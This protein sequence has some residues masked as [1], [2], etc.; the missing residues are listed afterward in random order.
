VTLLEPRRR[1]RLA[2][3]GSRLAP[4]RVRP[5][6]VVTVELYFRC[7]APTAGAWEVF[8]HADA[9]PPSRKPRVGNGDHGFTG[10]AVATSG[11]RRGQLLLDRWDLEISSGA[12]TGTYQLFAGLWYP[13]EGDRMTVRP[14]QAVSSP[15]SDGEPLGDEY[16]DRVYLGDVVV[17]R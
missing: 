2:L 10:G 12:E 1:G 3:V 9:P 7:D 4:A 5:G 15:G 8:I 11:C 16:A 14:E 13:P 6:G 17:A